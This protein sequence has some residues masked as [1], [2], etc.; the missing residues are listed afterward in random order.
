MMLLLRKL[1]WKAKRKVTFKAMVFF[2]DRAVYL[3]FG[4]E[5]KKIM[6]LKSTL[7][8]GTQP[9]QVDISLGSSNQS[10]EAY[11]NSQEEESKRAQRGLF[12]GNLSPK[13]KIFAL[14]F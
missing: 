10:Q 14:I 1:W 2:Q 11:V 5:L 8:S 9:E 12:R 4:K 3:K 6:K 13:L 7:E